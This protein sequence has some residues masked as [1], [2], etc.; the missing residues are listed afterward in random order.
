MRLHPRRS[1]SL[2]LTAVLACTVSATAQKIGTNATPGQA[3]VFKLKVNSQLVVETVV[4]Q[5]NKGAFVPDL[6]AGD[7]KVTEDGVPQTVRIFQHQILSNLSTS[8]PATPP[9]DAEITLYKRLVPMRIIPEDPNHSQYSDHRLLV[10]YFDMTAMPYTDQQRALDAARKFIRTRMSASDLAAIVWYTGGA[11]QVLQNFTANR[12]RLLSILETMIVGQ[13]QGSV[14]SVNDASSADT[15]VA[16]GQDDSEFN[17]FN[18]DRQLAA[19]RTAV[20][21][22]GD[23]KEKKQ[24]IYFASGMH[25]SGLDNLAQLHATI[26]AALRAGVSFWPID[27]RGLVAEAPL[28]DAT[29]GSP[30]NAGMYSGA[31]ARAVTRDFQQSQDTLYTLG[32]DT[33][34]KALFDN[35]NLTQGIVQAQHAIGNYYIIGYYATNTVQNGRYRRIKIT[36]NSPLAHKLEYRRGYY[37]GKTFQHFT[38][39]NKE[40]QL[41]DAMMLGDPITQLTISMEVDYFQLNRAQYFVPVTVDIPGRELVLAQR[42]G[43]S[44]TVIDFL[45]EIRDAATGVTVSNLRDHVDIKLTDE[46]AAQLARRRVE[47]DSGFTLFPGRY[48]IKFL[49]RDDETGRIGTFETYFVI[50]NLNVVKKRVAISAVILGSQRVDV[51][52]ALYNAVRGKKL[53]K[54]NAA[55][56][57]VQ[58]GSKLIPA[59]TRVFHRDQ[60]LYIYLQAYDNDPAPPPG[61]AQPSAAV[62]K[63]PQPYFVYVSQYLEGKLA[64]QTGPIAVTAI[65]GTRLGVIPIN[66]QIGL[67][68]LAP[69]QYRC[70]VTVLDPTGHRAAFWQGP[71]MLM[72]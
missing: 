14:E 8:L 4:V 72:E 25:L 56:P 52:G 53:A 10:L 61:T 71:F 38:K 65:S 54:D 63:Q 15:G 5:D 26:E 17:L 6:T 11:I 64:L 7:F 39:A 35:N 60:N 3:G 2:A 48:L 34:G 37:A 58:N 57:L 19:L 36:L 16:F 20:R 28:G 32:A 66:F 62:S 46:T 41:E 68:T 70:E 43:A 1:L 44:H 30:G 40:R 29:Q 59:V 21:M 33:G 69:G 47:Y 42:F 23:I 18:N 13:G 9:N 51:G 55:N 24:L 49:A 67:G 45:C 50:P 27:A 31:A 22:L 12:I